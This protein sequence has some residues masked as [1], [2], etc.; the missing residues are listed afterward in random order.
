MRPS[1]WRSARVGSGGCGRVS[2]CLALRVLVLRLRRAGADEPIAPLAEVYGY[3]MRLTHVAVSFSLFAPILQKFFAFAK[4]T[5]LNGE[6]LFGE[7]TQGYE[8]ATLS[9][10]R[11]CGIW[12]AWRREYR[13]F[14]IRC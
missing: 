1:D 9:P 5:G 2:L 6:Q 11:R 10:T 7:I 13:R 12:P 4:E 8:N 3:G 14:A